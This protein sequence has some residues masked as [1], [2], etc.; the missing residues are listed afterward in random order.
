M[1][2][3]FASQLKKK[4]PSS[5]TRTQAQNCFGTFGAFGKSDRVLAL[6]NFWH[7][8]QKKSCSM[9]TCCC[10]PP[11]SRAVRWV[12][13]CPETN[14]RSRHSST[15]VFAE[16]TDTANISALILHLHRTKRETSLFLHRNCILALPFKL[17]MFLM[18]SPAFTDVLEASVPVVQFERTRQKPSTDDSNW[19]GS[20]FGHCLMT[21]HCRQSRDGQH[22]TQ[23]SF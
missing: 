21:L 2:L 7:P 3:Q 15:F 12:C 10:I 5:C 19:K 22:K 1:H 11:S 18:R 20:V 4:A 16:E 9:S 23:A 6:P 14:F 17:N 13:Q 8:C